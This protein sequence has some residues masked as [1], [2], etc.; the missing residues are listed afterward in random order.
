MVKPIKDNNITLRVA[1]TERTQRTQ[2]DPDR[3]RRRVT[4]HPQE[5]HLLPGAF[6]FFRVW[7]KA[8]RRKLKRASLDSRVD[9]FRAR[10]DLKHTGPLDVLRPRV[11]GV[12]LSVLP[13]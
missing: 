10:T 4:W 1:A 9:V 7:E 8:F 5:K 13:C 11:L 12:P 6:F 3:L 2:I